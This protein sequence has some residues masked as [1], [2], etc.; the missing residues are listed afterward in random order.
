M[1]TIYSNYNTSRNTNKYRYRLYDKED[2]IKDSTGKIVYKH[3]SD[4]IAPENVPSLIIID[5]IS[6]YDEADLS[7][8]ND[9]AKKYGITVLTA[10]DFDQSSS[11]AMVERYENTELQLSPKRSFF[12]HAPK[13]GV[14]M[15]TS[16][17]QLDKTLASFRTTDE[18][19]VVQ[20]YYYE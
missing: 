4:D 18:N 3:Q 6:H 7:L 12:K 11:K 8:I 9:F 15:R 2:W 5:E 19:D 20:T 17:S 16:N 1:T 13:L 10:G 14:S